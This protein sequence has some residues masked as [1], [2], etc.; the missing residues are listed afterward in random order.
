MAIQIR[1]ADGV[2]QDVVDCL[3]AEDFLG[4]EPLSMIERAGG[5]DS[6]P[7]G[8]GEVVNP[9]HRLAYEQ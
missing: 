2:M 1:A 6:M 9:F 5:P 8:K 7:F 4:P 3:L